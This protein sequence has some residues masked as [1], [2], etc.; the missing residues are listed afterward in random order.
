MSATESI[1]R[2]ALLVVAEG[3]AM[4]AV[5]W[6]LFRLHDWRRDRREA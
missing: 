2:V 5:L 3:A 1:G 4:L 6:V